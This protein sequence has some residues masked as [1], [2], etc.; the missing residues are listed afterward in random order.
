NSNKATEVR[1][2]FSHIAPRYDFLNHAL[3][4]N[5][6]RRWRRFLVGKVQD[7]LKRPGAVALDLCCGTGDLAIKLADIG[8]TVG[9]DFCQPMLAI[10]A[11]K[12]KGANL[13]IV[14]VE[15]DGL[16]IPLSDESVDVVTVAFGLRNVDG[17][18]SGLREMFRVLKH[19]GRVA[20]LEFSRPRVPVFR[21]I[22]QF[23]FT[24]VLP[25]VGNAISGS[26]HAY[27]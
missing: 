25:R 10:G 24:K 21:S 11:R 19:G 16:R 23:Y 3:S 1:A 6:D 27:R 15:G 20:V 26:D 13:P 5:V 7:V 8:P 4:L 2:M 14:L 17:L 18:E 22:F 12:I 9:V